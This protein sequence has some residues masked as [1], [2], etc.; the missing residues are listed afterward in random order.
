MLIVLFVY[1]LKVYDYATA[2]VKL[3]FEFLFLCVTIFEC[4]PPNPMFHVS[5]AVF[6]V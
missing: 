4:Y 6:I 2:F 5:F 3:L 1:F